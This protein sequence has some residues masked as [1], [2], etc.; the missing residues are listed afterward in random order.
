MSNDL[1]SV[2]LIGRLTR[3]P[4]IK[5]TNSG[6]PVT[7][8]S[9]ASGESYTKDGQKVENTNYFDI[10]VWGNQA[11]SCEK[12]LKKGSQVAVNGKLKQERWQDQASG[13]TRSKVGITANSVQFLS[14]GGQQQSQQ[15]QQQYTQQPQQ[16]QPT[17][18]QQNQQAVQNNFVNQP[19]QQDPYAPQPQNDNGIP[20]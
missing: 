10:T 16:Q 17:V 9:I 5:Y 11:G 4:E 19:T 14:S 20:F 8:F 7:K 1:N 18:G 6:T 2:F 3:D 12:Y 15:T 13:Q